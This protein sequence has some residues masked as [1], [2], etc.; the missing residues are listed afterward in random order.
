VSGLFWIQF[1]V[2][3]FSPSPD[4]MESMLLRQSDFIG[5]GNNP[6]YNVAPITSPP[7]R[8]KL[9]NQELFFRFS[10]SMGSLAETLTSWSPGV[11]EGEGTIIPGDYIS[12]A[13]YK[14]KI[15]MS[16]P[17][18]WMEWHATRKVFGSPEVIG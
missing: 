15:V 2:D 5:Q 8:K 7:L 10:S 11:K 3:G 4:Y 9:P 17:A 14:L 13:P 1:S 12:F 6:R 18:A 16:G